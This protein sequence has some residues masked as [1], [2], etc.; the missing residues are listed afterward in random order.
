MRPLLRGLAVTTSVTFC[1]AASCVSS[2][3]GS[4]NAVGGASVISGVMVVSDGG[5]CLAVDADCTGTI[6]YDQNGN[7]V[8]VQP[9][10]CG[11][12]QCYLLQCCYAADCGYTCQPPLGACCVAGNQCGDDSQCCS[13]ICILSDGAAPSVGPPGSCM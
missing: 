10:C 13:G 12:A 4:D 5:P 2:S 1:V 8:L 6:T 11:G 3:T 9:T 7:Q